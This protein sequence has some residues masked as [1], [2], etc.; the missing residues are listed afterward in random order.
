MFALCHNLVYACQAEQT[1]VQN[2]TACDFKTYVEGHQCGDTDWA[3]EQYQQSNATSCV[4]DKEQQPKYDHCGLYLYGPYHGPPTA[5]HL[6]GEGENF[7][8][9][10]FWANPVSRVTGQRLPYI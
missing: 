9:T 7:E 2:L 3:S 6:Q 5:S 10:Q 1:F 8:L 4:N